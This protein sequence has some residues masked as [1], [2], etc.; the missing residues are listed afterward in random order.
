[1]GLISK[2]KSPKRHSVRAHI[3][4]AKPVRSYVR[5]K[6]GEKK[7]VTKKRVLSKGEP[8]VTL[9]DKK[10]V[11]S[12]TDK[13]GFAMES[14][15]PEGWEESRPRPTRTEKR[16]INEIYD[17]ARHITVNK[18]KYPKKMVDLAE[19]IVMTAEDVLNI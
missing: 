14:I 15:E 10:Y 2:R 8:I 11:D 16:K 3:K 9:A 19:D 4:K 17:R 7:K 12:M 6:G 13:Y 1:V 18:Q 5:G